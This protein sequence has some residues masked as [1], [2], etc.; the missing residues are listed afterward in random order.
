MC[1]VMHAGLYLVNN[2]NSHQRKMLPKLLETLLAVLLK[3]VAHQ[4]GLLMHAGVQLPW[5]PQV[6]GKR[7]NAWRAG[8]R[9]QE[10]QVQ[11][12]NQ[13]CHP[14]AAG[15][16]CRKEGVLVYGSTLQYAWQV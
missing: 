3:L 7:H 9:F 10:S 11:I 8:P 15:Q 13:R 16:C 14:N 4:I 12:Q 6:A 1:Q 2:A 5:L